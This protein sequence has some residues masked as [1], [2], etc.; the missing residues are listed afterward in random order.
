VLR[1][2][3]LQEGQDFPLLQIGSGIFAANQSADYEWKS[4]KKLAVA[5]V[6][7]LVKAYPKSKEYPLKPVHLELRYVDVLDQGLIAAPD[8][9][10]F[11][12]GA[13]HLD[14]RPPPY[15]DDPKNFGVIGGGRVQ[16]VYPVKDRQDTSFQLDYASGFKETK[17]VVQ[18]TTK[19]ISTGAGVPKTATSLSSSVDAWLDAAHEL[20]SRFFKEFVRPETLEHFK[21]KV[22][23]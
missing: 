12:R 6:N 1:R 5:G 2:Y 8:F 21:Q 19:V 3:F 16:L 10:A 9:I 20:L 17:A 11:T 14:I 15:F 18:L 13:T 23:T 7:N 22:E 4:F